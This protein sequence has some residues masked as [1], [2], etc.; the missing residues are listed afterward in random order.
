MIGRHANPR[1]ITCGLLDVQELNWKRE[2]NF[3]FLSASQ[4]LMRASSR[5]DSV[6]PRHP[7]FLL[8]PFHLSLPPSLLSGTS[9]ILC[10][11]LIPRLIASLLAKDHW[12]SVSSSHSLILF[13]CDPPRPHVGNGDSVASLAWFN[14]PQN[15]SLI[16]P[17]PSTLN[18]HPRRF[19]LCALPHRRNR[20][21]YHC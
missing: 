5:F 8:L 12:H 11:L 21:C 7:H 13:L 10:I 3:P 1:R 2:R 4:F 14:V 6:P 18:Q 15:F 20:T 16:G 9:V 19:D 17:K